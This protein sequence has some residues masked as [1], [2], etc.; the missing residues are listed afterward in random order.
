MISKRGE[1]KLRRQ[2][3]LLPHD[4][5]FLD[6]YS[7]PWETI[8]DGS[9][10]VLVHDFPTDDGYSPAAASIAIRIETGYPQTALDMVYVYPHLDR[11]DGKPIPCTEGR[12]RIDD[13]DWQRW[14]R[15]RSAAN[16]WA[17]GEDSIEHHVYLVDDWFAREF[18]K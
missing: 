15:H 9:H 10:W 3:A 17:P 12:Q 8:V 1:R 11:R 16:P 14:S 4:Q 2:F 6:K 7:L 13:V 5:E 18:E